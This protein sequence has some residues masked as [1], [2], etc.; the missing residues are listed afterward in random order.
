M[1]SEQFGGAPNRPPIQSSE[2]HSTPSHLATPSS[3]S[4][5]TD[6][7]PYR[8]GTMNDLLASSSSSAG[9]SKKRKS[10]PTPS[11]LDRNPSMSHDPQTDDDAMSTVSRPVGKDHK[12]TR[13]HFSCVE[14]H[15]RKQKCDRK[16]PCSQCVARRVPHLCR[17]FLNGVEDPNSCVATL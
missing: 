2:I 5:P 16:E 14:C 4:R 17:P 12:R 11:R 13:V 15:R 6:S 1:A 7:T 8:S 9:P 3:T 10:S